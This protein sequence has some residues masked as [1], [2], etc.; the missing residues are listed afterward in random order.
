V[1]SPGSA[2]TNV[3]GG[4][5]LNG[6]LIASCVRNIRIKNYQNLIISFQVTVKNVGDVFL[7]HSVH[8]CHLKASM[9]LPISDQ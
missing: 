9:R 2:E 6:N 1:F 7:G 8:V 3:E 5:K 4:K